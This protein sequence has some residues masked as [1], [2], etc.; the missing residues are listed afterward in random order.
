[1]TCDTCNRQMHYC[2]YIN[3]AHWKKAIGK[4]EGYRCAHCILE[5]LGGQEWYILWNEP[6]E[7]M[8][9][10]VFGDDRGNPLALNEKEEGHVES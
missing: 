5:A 6:Q 2:F 1:M 9:S 3:D 7:R 4:K 10:Q 8:A